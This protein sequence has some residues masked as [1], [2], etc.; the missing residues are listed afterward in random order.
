MTQAHWE[1][2]FRH[3]GHLSAFSMVNPYYPPVGQ[4]WENGYDSL[5]GYLAAEALG[6]PTAGGVAKLPENATEEGRIRALY[7]DPRG[8]NMK[9]YFHDAEEEMIDQVPG[10]GGDGRLRGTTWAVNWT[11]EASM[12]TA[13]SSDFN[14]ATNGRLRSFSLSFGLFVGNDL[15][16]NWPYTRLVAVGTTTNGWQVEFKSTGWKGSNTVRF[17]TFKNGATNIAESSSWKY[18]DALYWRT[19]TVT[20]TTNPGDPSKLDVE[21]KV[22]PVGDD[23]VYARTTT[24]NRP[25]A[26]ADSPIYLLTTRA[27]S[28]VQ[29]MRDLDDFVLRDFTGETI[30]AYDFEP[31]TPGPIL[32]T[33]P[34]GTVPDRSGHG[35]ALAAPPGAEL[36]FTRRP[37][38][39]IRPELKAHISK[40]LVDELLEARAAAGRPPPELID[41]WRISE[42]PGRLAAWQE[43]GFTHGSGSEAYWLNPTLA[44][45][46]NKVISLVRRGSAPTRFAWADGSDW[47]HLWLGTEYNTNVLAAAEY[48]D[49]VALQVLQGVRWFIVFTSMSNGHLAEYTM[50]SDPASVAIFNAEAVYN[51]C[52]VASWFQ[53]TSATLADSTLT[54]EKYGD[55]AIG[56]DT[57]Y[58]RRDNA[59]TKEAWFAAIKVAGSGSYAVSLPAQKGTIRNLKTGATV[60]ITNGVFS[61]PLTQAA[62]P[63]HF[64]EQYSLSYAA[65][66]G[67]TLSGATSQAVDRGADGAA[68][69][70]VPDPGYFFERWSDGSTGNPRTDT[71]VTGAVSVT[72]IFRPL[73]RILPLRAAAPDEHTL[74]WTSIG[75]IRYRAQYA[76]GAPDGSYPES[77]LD[78]VR[79]AGEETDPAATGL[80][81]TMEFTDDGTRT[82]GHAPHGSRYYR[83]RIV[84]AGE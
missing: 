1:N 82:G 7:A 51:L 79:P 11:N 59:A 41:N 21:V 16:G 24:V 6:R 54:A 81:G 69:T 9:Y 52:Q 47:S 53:P 4:P 68:V 37:T 78:I 71:A 77:F 73:P 14:C 63:Y 61:L 31:E 46:E 44:P 28:T 80:E 56:A 42:T 84:P 55:P 50:E 39:G 20:A 65:G 67:G 74:T 36:N 2:V 10:G 18:A 60:A 5:M 23:A 25:N 72:A 29:M 22:E 19:V 8:L 62:E 13:V 32:E 57:L 12:R 17:L 3:V 27:Q 33:L 75:G 45:G 58:I 83:I 35:H 30:V 15:Y 34:I 70:A 66:T 76:D 26:Y 40:W 38:H 49:L 64:L 48:D 43:E